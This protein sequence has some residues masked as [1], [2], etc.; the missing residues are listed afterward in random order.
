[1]LC[2]MCGARKDRFYRDGKYVWE[3]TDRFGGKAQ[4]SPDCIEPIDYETL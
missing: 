4:T 3:Y 1:M 2:T